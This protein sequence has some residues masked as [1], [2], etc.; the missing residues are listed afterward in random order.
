MDCVPEDWGDG[1]E[2]VIV[3]CTIEDQERADYRLPIFKSLPIRHKSIII[4]PLLGAMDIS[5]Y[6]DETI[7]EVSVGGESGIDARPCDY[8][9]VLSLRR[10]CVDKDIPFRFHQTGARFIKNG[11]LYRVPRAYQL[12]Q[13]HKA[14]IDYRIGDYFVPETAK[15]EWK[16]DDYTERDR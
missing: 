1:Y 12:S 13:A 15:Y 16:E 7:E 4:A 8:D 10:Q 9:W 2:N 6:L 5:R 11:R 3:G 14:N